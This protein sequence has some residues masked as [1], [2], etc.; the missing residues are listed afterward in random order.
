MP[1]K[2]ENSANAIK[3]KYPFMCKHMRV[4]KTFDVQ[5]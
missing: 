4:Q 5:K 2:Y 1:K 3:A